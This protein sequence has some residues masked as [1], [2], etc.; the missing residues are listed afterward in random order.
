LYLQLKLYLWQTYSQRISLIVCKIPC[1][2]QNK[3]SS[4]CKPS[5]T[6]YDGQRSTLQA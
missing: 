2:L 5:G 6:R 3:W 4:E 1:A